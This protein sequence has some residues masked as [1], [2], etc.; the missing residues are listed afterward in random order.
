[1]SGEG[2]KLS[3]LQQ[4]SGPVAQTD[5]LY[6]VR[7]VISYK[8][9]IS[10]L[11]LYATQLAD[12][13]SIGKN[14]L[15]AT[16]AAAVKLLLDLGNL[17]ELDTVDTGEI[18]DLA[19]TLDKLAN[20]TADSILIGDATNRP[21]EL[22]T[23]IIGRA[24]LAAADRAAACAAIGIAANVEQLTVS[25]GADFAYGDIGYIH[26]DGTVRKSQNDGTSAEAEA[27]VVCLEA[28]GVDDT[29]TGD[30]A[31]AGGFIPGLTG[32]SAGA[33][34]YIDSTP[35]AITNTPPV[36]GYSTIVGRWISAT[37]LL[38]KP[39]DPVLL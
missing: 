32:G 29:L 36:S 30:F 38:F 10:Q 23:S 4:L 33:L 28:D 2:S 9:A 6:L 35:G 37:V 27:E 1:M 21:I 17:A 16:D 3:I 14:I 25:G 12:A 11:R 7:G 13:S 18:Q 39:R 26:T 31:A 19:V 5:L 20:V 15:T 34:A 8:I 22:A 24:L